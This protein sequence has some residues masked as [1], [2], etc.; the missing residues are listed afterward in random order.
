MR[1][2]T[3]SDNMAIHT[4]IIATDNNTELTTGAKYYVR[5]IYGPYNYVKE[6]F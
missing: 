3:T 5:I 2:L 6:E 1:D 4:S